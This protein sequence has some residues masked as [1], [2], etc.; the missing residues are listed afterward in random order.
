MSQNYSRLPTEGPEGFSE[1]KLVVMYYTGSWC[2][3]YMAATSQRGDT[4]NIPSASTQA[5]N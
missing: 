5:Q 1:T 4:W 3:V 2:Q